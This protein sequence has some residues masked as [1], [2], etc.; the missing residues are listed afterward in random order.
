MSPICKICKKNTA[1]NKLVNQTCPKCLL[2][3]INGKGKLEVKNDNIII[4]KQS[5]EI[6]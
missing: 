6:S 3:I 4:R 5:K 2:K 1:S